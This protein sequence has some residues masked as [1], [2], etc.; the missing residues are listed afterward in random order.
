MWL[1]HVSLSL[2]FYS[3]TKYENQ[4]KAVLFDN[5]NNKKKL[6]SRIS[7]CEISYIIHTFFHSMSTYLTIFSVFYIY[8]RSAWL[9]IVAHA[10][11]IFHFFIFFPRLKKK[12]TCVESVHYLAC[13]VCVCYF[14]Y[15]KIIQDYSLCVYV[16]MYIYIYMHIYFSSCKQTSSHYS[17]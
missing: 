3:L 14:F 7:F 11:V 17:L 8:T 1:R 16:Y 15:L 5:N 12:K 13:F 6:S 4:N 10:N 9:C 2:F